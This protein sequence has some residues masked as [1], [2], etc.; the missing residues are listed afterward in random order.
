MSVVSLSSERDRRETEAWEH[1]VAARARADA[2]HNIVDGK[3][4]ALAWRAWIELHMTPAQTQ[5]MGGSVRAIGG[6]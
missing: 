6:R 2:T 5:W 3:A 1:Y 4:A